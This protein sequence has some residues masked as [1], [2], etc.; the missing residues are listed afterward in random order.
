MKNLKILV[1][2]SD[3]GLGRYL[4]KNIP[5]SIGLNRLNRKEILKDKNFDFIIHTAY[6]SD[7]IPFDKIDSKYIDDNLLLTK[8]L[9]GLSFLNFIYISSIDSIN[10]IKSPYGLFKKISEQLIKSQVENY[11]I[12]RP[13]HLINAGKINKIPNTIRKV[14]NN[15]KISLTK[16]SQFNLVCYYDILNLIKKIIKVKNNLKEINLVNRESITMSDVV[17]ILNKN[18]NEGSFEYIPKITEDSQKVEKT[19]T[20]LLKEYLKEMNYV[21]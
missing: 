12:I 16:N 13:T 9:L 8:D 4:H 20:K 19:S 18:V 5:N 11:T 7:N 21:F 1:T 3:S 15:E 14:M 17:K 2:G 6:N 10:K